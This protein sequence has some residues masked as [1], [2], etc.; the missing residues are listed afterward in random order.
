MVIV[1]VGMVH[2]AHQQANFS[3]GNMFSGHLFSEEGR[4]KGQVDV[5]EMSGDRVD[6]SQHSSTGP[7]NPIHENDLRIELNFDDIRV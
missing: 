1:R 3:V 7:T 2:R 4:S 5:M 6:N